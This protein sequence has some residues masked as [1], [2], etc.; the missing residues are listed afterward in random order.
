MR[1]QELPA[2]DTDTAASVALSGN[3]PAV[4]SYEFAVIPLLNGARVYSVRSKSVK[5]ARHVTDLARATC[6]CLAA[7]FQR[8]TDRLCEHQRLAVEFEA[9]QRELQE[10]MPAVTARLQTERTGE[11]HLPRV[12]EMTDD[13]LRSVFS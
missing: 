8:G 11:K 12:P 7:R 6:T 10:K 1:T 4:G 5:G 9:E 13:E 2:Q 3:K